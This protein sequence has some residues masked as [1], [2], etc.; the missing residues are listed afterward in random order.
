MSRKAGVPRDLVNLHGLPGATRRNV[1]HF[2]T[3][4]VAPVV[5]L[6][7]LAR[8]AHLYASYLRDWKAYERLPGA[9]PLRFSDSHP[10]LWDRTAETP[11]D[12]HY[13]YQAIWAYKAIHSS[14]A[15]SH[16]DFGSHSSFVGMLSA[17]THVTFVDI[18]PLC[19]GV[20]GLHSLQG[21]VLDIPF[22]RE[23]LGSV[24]CLH[25][26]EH[27]GLGR[28]G[29]PLDPM[30]TKKSAAELTRVLCPGGNLYFSA[31]IGR[32]RV[33]FNAHRIHAPEQIMDYFGDLELVEFAAVDDAGEFL[34]RANPRDFERARYT[35]GLFWFRKKYAADLD[36]VG[37][38]RSGVDP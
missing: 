3:S 24:S 25:V 1:H 30:G 18:R 28:Y 19:V 32:P 37:N 12:P 27:I 8:S 33:C 7:N 2:W 38:P 16:V 15:A 10:C 35:C 31:P 9:E 13:F 20:E 21:S 36:R 26:A 14:G 5:Q 4:W 29:D 11:F 17:I 34:G 6:G 23:T 22:E